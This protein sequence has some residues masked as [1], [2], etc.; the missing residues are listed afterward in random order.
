MKRSTLPTIA[1][2]L[3]CGTLVSGCAA[4]VVG[5]AAVGG[6]YLGKDDR[7]AD[8]IAK[9]AAIT[10]EVKSK[11]IGEPGIRSGQI[12]VDTYEGIVTLKGE[13]ASS[14]QGATAENLARSVKGV[15][16]VKTELKVK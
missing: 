14:E 9:D 15:K 4:A 3:A 11:L 13:V 12:N 5:G 2:L 7:S 8:V 6:Y 1:L 10:G 16:A